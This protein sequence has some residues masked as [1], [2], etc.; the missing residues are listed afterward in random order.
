MPPTPPPDID[1]EAWR[2]SE[3]RI[4]AWNPDSL[5]L[6]H[7][8][9]YHGP[10]LHFQAMFENIGEWSRIVQ[11]LLADALASDADRERRFIDE[12]SLDLKR[13]VG[14]NEADDYMR[15]GGLS[16]SWQGLSRY[17]RRKQ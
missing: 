9:P 6:T 7:F 5:F 1:L 13:R 2:D 4:L 11:R 3:Q 10:R 15:A 17:W 8:G 16:Y 14:P 12:A